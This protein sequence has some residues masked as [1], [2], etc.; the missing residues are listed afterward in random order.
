MNFALVF[1]PLFRVPF[2]DG[3]LLSLTIPLLGA[4]IR[5]REEWLAALGLAQ[6]TAAGGVLAVLAGV[7]PLAG[8][9]CA[10]IIAAIVKGRTERAGND[11]Y[12]VLILFGW[13]AALIGAANSVKGE[14]LSHRLLDGQLY[15]TGIPNLLSA[16][17][18]SLAVVALLP[19]LSQRLLTER[20]FPEHLTVNGVA[21]WRIHLAFDVLVAVGIA[22]STESIG[23]MATFGLVFFPSWTAFRI[24]RGWRQALLW[25]TAISVAAYLMAFT[26]AIVLNQPFAPVLVGVLILVSF[27]RLIRRPPAH[28]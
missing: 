28:A 5:L 25:I 9:I 13:S 21:A 8:A 19:R 18:L 23:V 4:Y 10:A 11:V 7:H 27:L 14:E 15:F 16:L 6:T 24:A 22:L 12:G 20:F 2:L 3:L 17:I 1:D 26:A